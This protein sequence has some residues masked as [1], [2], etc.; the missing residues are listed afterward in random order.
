MESAISIISALQDEGISDAEGV[1]DLIFDYA[2]LDD[3]VQKMHDMILNTKPPSVEVENP[4]LAYKPRKRTP[5]VIFEH[6]KFRKIFMPEIHEQ[7]RIGSRSAKK[8]FWNMGVSFRTIR[9]G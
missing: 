8:P 5:K 4:E 3:E 2:H 6:G 7:L 1:K 9:P